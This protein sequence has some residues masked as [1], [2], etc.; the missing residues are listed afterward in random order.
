MRKAAIPPILRKLFPLMRLDDYEKAKKDPLFA[1]YTVRLCE[2]CYLSVSNG[3][4]AGGVIMRSAHPTNKTTALKFTK[5]F[6]V[7]TF[8]LFR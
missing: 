3:T 5:K 6:N 7:I 1:N 4:E 2:D 8:S